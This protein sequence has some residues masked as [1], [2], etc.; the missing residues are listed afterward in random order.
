MR[1]PKAPFRTGLVLAFAGAL[2]VLTPPE[3]E[4][5]V[6]LRRNA[7]GLLEAT[8]SPDTGDFRLRYGKG[9]LIHSR[10]FK[11]R[12]RPEFDPLIYDA[13]ERFRLDPNLIKAV[14][15][16][17]SD[18]DEFA[19]SSKGAQGLM[20]L[21]PATARRFGVRNSFDPRQA[22]AGGAEY[23]RYL[24]DLFGGNIDHVLAGYNAGEGAVMRYRGVPPYRETRNYVAKIRAIMDGGPLVTTNVR[25][26]SSSTTRPT[27]FAAGQLPPSLQV[28]PA[29]GASR[30]ATPRAT[31]AATRL[32][33][34]LFYRWTDEAGAVH[35]ADTPPGDGVPFSTIR[36]L[37]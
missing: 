21:M 20:Q 16:V 19:V 17:E 6:Y 1:R 33:P 28:Q 18:Y 29:P 3:A 27:S 13:A 36:G 14:M 22:I 11:R 35:L 10:G 7:Q 23:L 30:K 37:N 34:R 12:A 9:V 31:R 4:A 8:D 25:T 26:A 32:P 15:S 24:V 5:Q 2:A